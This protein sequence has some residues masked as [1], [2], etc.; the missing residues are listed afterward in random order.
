MRMNGDQKG[1]AEKLVVPKFKRGS[2]RPF[3]RVMASLGAIVATITRAWCKN[4]K[5]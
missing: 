3:W 4:V 5:I 2:A 1:R